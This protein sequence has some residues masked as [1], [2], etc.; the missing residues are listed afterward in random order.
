MEAPFLP[1]PHPCLRRAQRP[2]ALALDGPIWDPGGQR[3]VAAAPCAPALSLRRGRG[4]GSPGSSPDHLSLGLHDLQGARDAVRPGAHSGPTRSGGEGAQ[5]P[6]AP[7]QKPLA[8]RQVPPACCSSGPAA[9]PRGRY[10][11]RGGTARG[12]GW[13]GTDGAWA[14]VRTQGCGRDGGAKAGSPAP[15]TCAATTAG[16]G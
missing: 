8:V 1:R 12:S 4:S 16:R 13:E 2:P 15:R 6:S 7:E 11:D 10:P 3:Q 14:A 5:G 9:W